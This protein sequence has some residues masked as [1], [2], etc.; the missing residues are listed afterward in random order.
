VPGTQVKLLNGNAIA[1]YI[2]KTKGEKWF[3]PLYVTDYVTVMN[4]VTEADEA[5]PLLAECRNLSLK[6][7]SSDQE[8]MDDLNLAYKIGHLINKHVAPIVREAPQLFYVLPNPDYNWTDAEAAE[9][10]QFCFY[11][12]VAKREMDDYGAAVCVNVLHQADR[13]KEVEVT[14]QSTIADVNTL[15]KQ[16]SEIAKERSHRQEKE[17]QEHIREQTK[18]VTFVDLAKN[19]FF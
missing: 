14:Q 16:M 10:L 9:L 2:E 4:I 3:M 19:I 12:K 8:S 7:I 15:K 11:N 5:C 1:K 17:T 13:L 18:P 6:V